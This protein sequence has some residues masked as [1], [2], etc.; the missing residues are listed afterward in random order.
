MNSEDSSSAGPLPLLLSTDHRTL[1][2][3][4]G[5]AVSPCNSLSPLG[6]LNLSRLNFVSLPEWISK[7][8]NLLRLDLSCCKR[9]REISELP[10]KI[11]WLSVAGCESLERFSKLSNLLEHNDLQSLVWIDLSHCHRLRDNLCYDS[12][13]MDNVVQKNQVLPCMKFGVLLPGSK[14]PQRFKSV[15]LNRGYFPKDYYTYTTSVEL[16]PPSKWENTRLA[17][18]AV[19]ETR[20]DESVPGGMFVSI[21][22]NNEQ[23]KVF[24]KHISFPGGLS[25]DHVWL[26][27][28]TLSGIAYDKMDPIAVK[29]KVFISRGSLKSCGI[30]LDDEK[31]EDQ[32]LPST[33]LSLEKLNPRKRKHI[34]DDEKDDEEWLSST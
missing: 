17:L 6:V 24:E 12:T 8:S 28:F 4:C 5:P 14:V 27:Y 25:A 9:L 19:V 7:C 11:T 18:C 23:R 22:I 33:S 16:P 26:H 15:T 13:M 2:N 3:T 32:W 34:Q 10:P 21:F 1:D 20:E 30:C 29:W 31:D